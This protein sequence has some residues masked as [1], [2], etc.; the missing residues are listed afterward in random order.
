M[1]TTADTP[2]DSGTPRPRFVF[3]VIFGAL[4]LVGNLL[5]LAAA[6]QDKSW[7]TLAMAIVV[8]PILNS[9]FLVSGLVAIPFLKRRRV[10]FSLGRHLVLTLGVPIVAVVADFFIIMSMGFH[11]C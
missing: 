6:W 1:H 8:G 3:G 4:L 5:V 7:G 9:A 10:Q 11:P 2:A